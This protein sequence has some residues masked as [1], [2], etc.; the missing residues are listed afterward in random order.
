MDIHIAIFN[1]FVLGLE[2]RKLAPF[3]ASFEEDGFD[4]YFHS[5]VEINIGFFKIKLGTFF[6]SEELDEELGE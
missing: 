5:G 1:G 4:I 2:R 6:S 3:W